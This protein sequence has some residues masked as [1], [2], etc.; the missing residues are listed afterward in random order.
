MK[1]REQI[2]NQLLDIYNCNTNY[3]EYKRQSRG[4]SESIADII[5]LDVDRT[6]ILGGRVNPESIINILY[7]YSCYNHKV[8]YYQSMQFVAGFLFRVYEDE[9][10]VFKALVQVIKL[11]DM[12]DLYSNNVP[13]LK[14]YLHQLNRLTHMYRSL[15][16]KHFKKQEIEP[17]LYSSTWFMTLF[18]HHP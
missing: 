6:F 5:K 8:R 18:T 14:F 1:K 10:K 17:S 7:V 15:L 9:T 4:I 13:S 2:W 11:F 3:E 16:V 12:D